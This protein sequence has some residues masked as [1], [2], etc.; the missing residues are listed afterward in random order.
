LTLGLNWYALL[1][2]ITTTAVG[3]FYTHKTYQLYQSRWIFAIIAPF[4]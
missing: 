1:D 2:V 3:V 4:M